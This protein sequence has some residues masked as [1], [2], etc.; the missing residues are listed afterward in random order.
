[1]RE[2]WL[3]M[4]RGRGVG[5]DWMGPISYTRTYNEGEGG[6]GRMSTFPPMVGPRGWKKQRELVP[7]RRDSRE[8]LLPIC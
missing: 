1:M 4:I 7:I 3:E 6:E 5:K 8:L 2:A